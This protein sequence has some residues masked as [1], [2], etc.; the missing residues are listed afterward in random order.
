MAQARIAV[1]MSR[2]R[3]EGR[4]LLEGLLYLLP[5]LAIFGVFVFYPLANSIR[6]SLYQ[7][8]ILGNGQFFL[9][10]AQYKEIFT[11]G[12]F[13]VSLGTT[14]LY[15]AYLVIPGIVLSLCL[16]LMANWR[17]R[18]IG[19]YRLLFASPMVVAVASAS[20]IWMM[21]FS[22]AQ[23]VLKFF[24]SLFHIDQINWLADTRW[25]LFSVS[26]VAVWRTLGFNTILLL[27]GIQAVPEDM[28]ESSRIDGAGPWT[29]F[30]K[31]TLPMISPVLMFLLITST[32]SALQSFGEIN[33][34][35]QGGPAGV[36][37]VVVYSIYREAFFNYNFGFAAAEAMVL[38]AII[39]ALTL[40][41]FFVLERRVFYQ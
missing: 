21:F 26:M 19:V 32:I 16:A 29:M 30:W 6:L 12:E 20:L 15:A 33:M 31:M 23:G 25:A 3:R 18:G 34:L 41:Q 27:G 1:G 39:M 35:T 10:L 40:L 22:P 28:Y 37:N 9:G 38:F 7:T 4:K 2:S 14:A 11:L 13:G 17:L 24:L 8:D 5:A 36:T